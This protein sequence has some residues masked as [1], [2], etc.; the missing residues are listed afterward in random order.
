ML[1][2]IGPV[3]KIED[4]VDR[5]GVPTGTKSL[6]YFGYVDEQRWADIQRFQAP[7]KIL[8][9]GVDPSGIKSFA[10]LQVLYPRTYR[11]LEDVMKL[12]GMS[13]F[14]QMNILAEPPES[15]SKIDFSSCWGPNYIRIAIPL[16]EVKFK[17]WTWFDTYILYPL[18]KLYVENWNKNHA[19]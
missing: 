15:Y 17:R 4:D 1:V 18:C 3:N 16:G 19:K 12:S 10:D 14:W 7:L 6:T 2:K 13:T 5:W 9:K 11:Y 8:D